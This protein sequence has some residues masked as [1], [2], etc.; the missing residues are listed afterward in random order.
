M[1]VQPQSYFLYDTHTGKTSFLFPQTTGDIR[2]VTEAEEG[3]FLPEPTRAY[4]IRRKKEI[5]FMCFH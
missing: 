2:C 5:H 4:D 3:H 1:D